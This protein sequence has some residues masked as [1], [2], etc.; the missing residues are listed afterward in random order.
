MHILNPPN[1]IWDR[2]IT[3]ILFDPPPLIDEYANSLFFSSSFTP[4]LEVV[5]IGNDEMLIQPSLEELQEIQGFKHVEEMDQFG[6][7]QGKD[8]TT[9]QEEETIPLL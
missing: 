9:E 7:Q 2:L 8:E 5:H 6:N 3:A 1:K 4:M